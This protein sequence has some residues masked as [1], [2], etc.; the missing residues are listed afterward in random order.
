MGFVV[1]LLISSDRF[2]AAVAL[3]CFFVHFVCAFDM[4]RLFC[5][6][7]FSF[8]FFFFFFFLVPKEGCSS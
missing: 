5:H 3:L 6:Y 7:F 8:L 4:L 2:K 1:F